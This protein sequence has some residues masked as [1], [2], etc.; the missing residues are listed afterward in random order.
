ML[1]VAMVNYRAQEDVYKELNLRV[2]LSFNHHQNVLL[3]VLSLTSSKHLLLKFTRD[4]MKRKKVRDLKRIPF[5]IDV[6]P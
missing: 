6:G 4:R 2:L 1:W 3:Y 5:V